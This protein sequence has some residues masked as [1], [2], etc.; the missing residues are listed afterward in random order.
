MKTEKKSPQEFLDAAYEEAKVA[1]EK[2]EVPIGCVVV[3]DG[4]IIACAH[5]ETEDTSD[6]TKHA[7]VIA[8]E[9]AVKVLGKSLV[10]CALFVTVEPCA[11]CAGAI[12]NSKVGYLYY[13]VEE[14]KSGCC[15]S[16]YNLVSDG[17]L[18]WRVK[19]STN[20]HDEKCKDLMQKF[21]ED[22]R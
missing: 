1:L 2:N 8:I 14:P 7:E 10:D 21:F 6:P 15:E 5:N 16:L 3:K 20:M 22:R 12:V 11:M 19:K 9:K 4:E 13:G 18:N 17:R